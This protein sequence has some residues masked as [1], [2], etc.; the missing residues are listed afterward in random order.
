MYPSI[1]V[2]LRGHVENLTRL[3]PSLNNFDQLEAL[4]ATLN[5]TAQNVSGENNR[6]LEAAMR[7][8]A[9]ES[10]IQVSYAHRMALLIRRM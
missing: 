1:V 2:K 9:L 10:L 8:E 7:L 5:R 6:M 3:M 4:L